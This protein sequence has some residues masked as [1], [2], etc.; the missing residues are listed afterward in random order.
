MPEAIA[1]VLRRRA[2]PVREAAR[3]CE[4]FDAAAD[5]WLRLQAD[6]SYDGAPAGRPPPAVR[7]APDP[8]QSGAPRGAAGKRSDAALLRAR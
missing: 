1:A 5:D 6:V 7:R 4:V 8:R 2:G 3:L